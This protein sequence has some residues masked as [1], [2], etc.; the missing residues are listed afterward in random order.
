MRPPD[1]LTRRELD[2]LLATLPRLRAG[3]VAERV[4]INVVRG[5]EFA[6]RLRNLDRRL[7]DIDAVE[8][9]LT[10][11]QADVDHLTR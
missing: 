1:Y 10:D 2:G 6:E 9:W 8:R 3:V 7:A 5:R 11:A 4:R